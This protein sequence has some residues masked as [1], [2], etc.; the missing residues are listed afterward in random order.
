MSAKTII[1]ACDELAWPLGTPK[2][3]WKKP[4]PALKKF[5]DTD[6]KLKKRHNNWVRPYG[7]SC[8]KA[9]FIAVYKSGHD[10]K[11]KNSLEYQYKPKNWDKSKWILVQGGVK[12]LD[13]KKFQAG[14]VIVTDRGGGGHIYIIYKAAKK[15]SNMI[16]AE[17]SYSQHHCLH[18]VKRKPEL[19]QHPGHNGNWHWRP[20]GEAADSSAYTTAASAASTASSSSSS[21]GYTTTGTDSG[22]A[23]VLEKEIAKLYSSAG[24]D[25]IS[26]PEQEETEE[27]RQNREKQQSI[28]DYL[29]N[30]QVNESI[31]PSDVIIS[32]TPIKSDKKIINKLDKFSSMSSGQSLISYPNM[33]E[34][35][36]IELSFNGIT[37]GG[38]NNSGDKYPNYISSM[39]ATKING[40]INTYNIDLVYQIRSGEDPNFID[41]LLSHTG[42]LNPL[43]SIYGD[44]NSPGLIFKEESAIITNVSSRDNV[45]SSSITYSI[46]AISSITS[47]DRSYYTFNE[48]SGKPSTLVYDLLYNSGQVSTQLLD[49]FPSM[50]DKSFVSSNNLIPTTDSSVVVGGMSDVSPLTY[51]SHVVSCM[52]NTANAATSYFLTYN[53]SKN[54]AYFKISEVSPI[55]N[56]NVLYEVDVGYPGNNFV[57]NFQLCDNIYWPLVYDYNSSIS[58]WDYSID[59]KGNITRQLNNSLY[60][61]N[62]FLENNIINSNW[63]KS[64]TEFP[65][66]AKLT[67]KGLAIPVMLMTYIR[68]NTLFY[69]QKDIASGIYVV[70][71]QTDSVSG[72]GYSTT[73]TL[74]RVSD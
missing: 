10:K 6:P 25:W 59:N 42:Y 1:Q 29:S 46:Q 56:S 54:G 64:L 43:K 4:T 40:R 73:L 72:S 14:D 39:T 5:L 24:Y 67:L 17:G 30:I 45:S 61:D 15:W 57:T 63:W 28:K 16:I 12:S 48:K 32:Y 66:S 3:K 21:S 35:P 19:H 55:M 23:I 69:G 34:A 8:D 52:V 2:S 22:A 50:R 20:I 41:K 47:A 58:K 53:D 44:S 51:L 27:E 38:Y 70:T 65:I 7:A 49:A 36:T 68:V 11:L 9:V 62:K 31:V 26:T 33:V 60:S 74:L 18:I 37:I 71:D 13:T